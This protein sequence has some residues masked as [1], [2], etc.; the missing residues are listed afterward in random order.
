[1]AEEKTKK[2]IFLSACEA[3]GDRHCANL[4]AALKKTGGDFD[5]V[6]LGGQRM[7][8]AGCRLLENTVNKAAMLH[9]AFGQIGF[10]YGVLRRTRAYFKANKIDLVIVCDSPA[11][12][13]HIAKAA[14]KTGTKTLFYVAPQ[15]WAWAQWRISKLRKRCDKL[16]C[17]LP[18]EEDW[19]SQRG[20]DCVYVGNPLFDE[21]DFEP[22]KAKRDF[23]GFDPNN[24]R[25]ALLPGSRQAEID[26]LWKPM[27]QIAM[28]LKQT[29][30]GI[31]FATVAVD[32]KTENRLRDAQIADFK[33]E[34]SID[35]V[36]QTT[37]KVDFT[38]VASGSATLQVA[39]AGCPMVIMYQASRL[40]WHCVGRWLLKTEFYS[41]VNILAERRLVPEFMPYF[42]SIEPIFQACKGM[43]DD[44]DMMNCIST[45]LVK[46]IEPMAKGSAS[47]KVAG[48]AI[49]MLG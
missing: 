21:I 18:F 48:L 9:K 11:F 2:T 30:P 13:F 37:A 5:F 16:A 39:A 19:F 14:K 31:E 10:F 47:E 46:L 35:S 6:G 27:Q 49:G 20:V 38:I 43:L 17:I 41:L 24:S 8:Q 3:S 23:T 25:I 34:Y 44:E 32:E 22:A 45:E 1:M 4:I 29:W 26:T 33:C 40:L 15:L 28:R 36:A 42:R 7:A 12:N